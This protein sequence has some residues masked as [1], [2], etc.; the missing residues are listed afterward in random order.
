MFHFS[1]LLASDRDPGRLHLYKLAKIVAYYYR[2]SNKSSQS[3]REPFPARFTGIYHLL[4][5]QS[6]QFGDACVL[7]RE[8]IPHRG[9]AFGAH[10]ESL[11]KLAHGRDPRGW[12]KRDTAKTARVFQ[13]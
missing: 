8:V 3:P 5:C 9:E 13:V 4:T 11:G 1:F 10:L 2:P 6:E 7:D 12:K